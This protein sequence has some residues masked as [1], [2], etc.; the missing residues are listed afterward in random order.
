MVFRARR[1]LTPVVYAAV[2]ALG[3]AVAPV[4]SAQ[5]ATDGDWVEPVPGEQQDP[6]VNPEARSADPDNDVSLEILSQQ[7]EVVTPDGAIDL[8][9]RV[10]N[11]SDRTVS[12]LQLRT[13]HQGALDSSGSV[14]AS[15]MSNQGEYPWAGEFQDLDGS[16]DPG[17]QRQF[18]LTVPVDGRS[19]SLAGMALDGPG[20][21]PLLLNLNADHGEEGTSFVAAARST[22]TVRDPEDTEETEDTEDTGNTGDPATG[23]DDPARPSGL[24]VLWPLSSQ[25]TVT[26]GQVGD[27]PEPSELY[28]SDDSLAG[29]LA[30]EGRLRTLLSSYRDA[31]SGPGGDELQQATCIAVDPDLLETV[32]RMSGGYRVAD[33]APS[34]VEEPVR[35]RDRWSG[36]RNETPS[37]EGTGADDAASWLDELR[38]I[39]DGQCTVPL[40]FSGSDP[41]AV[42][43]VE[44]PWLD[45]L[46]TRGAGVIEDVLDTDAATGVIVPGSGYLDEHAVDRLGGADRE[47]PLS[48]LVADNTVQNAPDVQE[49]QDAARTAGVTTLSGGTRALRYPE[50]LGTALAATG[51]HPT[52]SA[53]GDP[54]T[55]RNLDDDSPASRMAAAVGVLDLELRGAGST[56]PGANVLAVPPGEW[57]VSG[58]DAATWLRA[59][60]GHLA[61]GSARPVGFGSALRGVAVDGTTL[62]PTNDP[63]PVESTDIDSTRQ[64]TTDLHRFARIMVDDSD[65]A[66]T[67]QI[68]T[69]PMF[70]DLLRAL[71]D[72]RRRSQADT[73]D[74]TRGA[75]DRRDRVGGLTDSLRSS[76]SLLPPGNVFT[77]ASDS[78]PLI[79]VARNGLPLPVR[80]RVGYEAE[81]G[82]VLNT[83]GTE[84]IPAQGSVTLQMTTDI[85]SSVGDTDL[86]MTLNTPDELRIS[87]PVT[88]RL[89]SGPGIGALAVVVGVAVVFGLFAVSRVTK[90]RRQL[91]QEPD[92]ARRW[93]SD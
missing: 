54:G 4:V 26:P 66:L 39:V 35:L 25:S 68:F 51:D 55:R 20:V 63:A 84:Q 86:T 70:D 76:V 7:P 61:D 47:T 27:A 48:A 93:N 81:E 53:Y 31:L 71:S 34:P 58:D 77:R 67:S 50:A 73:V 29:E 52:T 75:T 8:R 38:D 57:T 79:V 14:A 36:D 23:T 1:V 78:S 6:W 82:V 5:D 42:A 46:S 62:P 49:P 15:L 37:S 30:P 41:N 11:D 85:P 83:P 56:T 28:L 91:A 24:T 16:L 33:T 89:A 3:L 80:V 2:V 21:Y 64:E 88:V 59:A 44:D 13:Q 12:G 9:L 22:V 32:D 45:D 69:R 18:R 65:V 43:A 19:G 90:R 87:E 72:N 10:S 60:A 92:S 74:T 17:E 40:P